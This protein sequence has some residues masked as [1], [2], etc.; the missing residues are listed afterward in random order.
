MANMMQAGA[1]KLNEWRDDYM[2]S[3]VIYSDGTY[4][5]IVSIPEPCETMAPAVDNVEIDVAGLPAQ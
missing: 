3:D 4:S 1:I 2:V 5:V